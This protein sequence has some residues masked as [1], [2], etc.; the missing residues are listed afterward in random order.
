MSYEQAALAR[1]MVLIQE[2]EQQSDRGTAIIGLAW[3]EEALH[4]AVVSYLVDDKSARDR[5]FRQSGPISTLSAKIDLARLLGMCTATIASD[6]HILRGIRNEFAHSV[7]AAD[8]TAL[9][10]ETTHIKDKCMSLKCVAHEELNRPRHAFVR[11][12]AVLNSDFYVHKLVGEKVAGGG[13][14]LA[15]IEDETGM[16]MRRHAR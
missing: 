5:L 11:A 6:L 13:Q 15:V 8:N 7:M 12:C 9:S 14:V 2:L 16:W 4:A 3:V 1:E 10:F